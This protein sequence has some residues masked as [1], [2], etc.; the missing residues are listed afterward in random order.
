MSIVPTA[1]NAS[2]EI[3]T[4][5]QLDRR[6]RRM[7]A[8]GANPNANT[9]N[10]DGPSSDRWLQLGCIECGWIP[11]GARGDV[12]GRGLLGLHSG[13]RQAKGKTSKG[14]FA[15]SAL[16]PLPSGCPASITGYVVCNSVLDAR[17]RVVLRSTSAFL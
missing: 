2:P 6:Q 16:P 1:V 5:G 9:T 4:E 12:L 8:D 13:Q 11:E 7:L 14:P 3:S 10:S 17:G 15:Q